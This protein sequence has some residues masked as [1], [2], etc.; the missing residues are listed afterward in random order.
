MFRLID[1]TIDILFFSINWKNDFDRSILVISMTVLM[2][3]SG[4]YL[5]HLVAPALLEDSN[6]WSC[7]R[8]L[9]RQTAETGKVR[10][11]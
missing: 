2:V 9:V 5:V 8:T 1:I 4:I 11:L 10:T 3:R 7:H 6:P